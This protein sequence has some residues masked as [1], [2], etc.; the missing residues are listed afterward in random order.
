M[1]ALLGENY[2]EHQALLYKITSGNIN[3]KLY[4]QHTEAFVE[5]ARWERGTS[6]MARICIYKCIIIKTD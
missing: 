5:G 6:Y 3:Y 2:P 1:T 4:V